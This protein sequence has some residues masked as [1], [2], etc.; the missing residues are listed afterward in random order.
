[1]NSRLFFSL[2]GVVAICAASCSD[3]NFIPDGGNRELPTVGGQEKTPPD[4]GQVDSSPPDL[5]LPDNLAGEPCCDVQF[6]V[7]NSGTGFAYAKLMGT[8][9]PFSKGVDLKENNGVWSATV[10][11]P[12]SSGSTYYYDFGLNDGDAGVVSNPVVNPFAPTGQSAEIGTVNVFV[13][14]LDCASLDKAIH[15]KTSN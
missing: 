2:L 14:A 7:A 3:E 12:A 15:S 13:P 4:L 10:C 11:V 1:M 8:E 9:D 6:A 5:I